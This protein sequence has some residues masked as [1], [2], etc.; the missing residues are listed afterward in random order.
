MEFVNLLTFVAYMSGFVG[1]MRR[2]VGAWNAMWWPYHVTK[3][4]TTAAPEN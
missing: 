3:L 1:A 2:G 4:I